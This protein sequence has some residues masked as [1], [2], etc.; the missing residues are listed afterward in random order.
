[1]IKLVQCWDDGV[2]DDIRLI[3]ILRNAGARASFN[4]N[5]GLHGAQRGGAWRYKD[6]KD[7]RRL[8]KSELTRVYEGF[9]IANHALTHPWPTHIPLDEW[10]REVNDGRKQLQDLFGQP[11]LG[12][13]F[14]YGDT[15]PETTAAVR[16]AGHIY[17]RGVGNAT[18][19][20]PP[21]DPLNCKPDTHFASPE[22][23]NRYEK[24]KFIGSPVFYF[25]GHSYEML[26]DREWQDFADK[27]ARLSADPDAVWA[28]LPDLFQTNP[29]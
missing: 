2:E 26:T 25:W 12:F 15:N 22:F 10:K 27:I 5:V 21:A 19:S 23:W 6:Q 16:E 24:A 7:V 11:V 28:N 4:L 20:Y 29:S 14:P 3:Q 8:A 13:A 18:P 1:M 9:T 17:A